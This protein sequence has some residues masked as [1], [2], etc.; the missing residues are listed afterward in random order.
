M[1][2]DW[3]TVGGESNMAKTV[4]AAT[5]TGEAA[6]PQAARGKAWL[7]AIMALLIVI[8]LA[9]GGAV[10]AV[11]KSHAQ[12]EEEG[13]A[14]RRSAA[15]ANKAGTAPIFVALE[16]FT[17]KLQPDHEGEDKYLQLVPALKALDLPAS[18][19]MKAYMPQIRHDMLNLL[20]GRKASQ[21]ADAQGM[22]RLAIDLR[23][24]VNQPLLDPRSPAPNA[25]KAGADDPVQAVLF[26]SL[27]IQ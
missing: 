19:R 15:K 22:E 6:A 21:L 25:D 26:S 20:S 11:K 7:W 12:D 5:K 3:V 10:W 17:V 16:V 24:R 23:N 13:D 4:A 1:L 27:I 14:P 8:L 2:S 9:G 18:E